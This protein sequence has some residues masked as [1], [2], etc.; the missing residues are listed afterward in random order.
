MQLYKYLMLV[1]FKRNNQQIKAFT[2]FY[3]NLGLDQFAIVN[4]C[5]QVYV[6]TEYEIMVYSC[7][8]LKKIIFAME[9]YND[10]R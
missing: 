5:S 6:S 8:K 1:V 3:C 2:E 10:H 9:N 7:T 4:L